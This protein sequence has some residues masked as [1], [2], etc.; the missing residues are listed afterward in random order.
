MAVVLVEG[1]A[2]FPT[3]PVNVFDIPTYIYTD[4]NTEGPE[5]YFI[6]YMSE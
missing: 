1:A 5:K 2:Q 6:D 3:I 4:G